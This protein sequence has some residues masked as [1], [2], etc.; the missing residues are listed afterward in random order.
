VFGVGLRNLEQRTRML[1]GAAATLAL[2][3]REGGGV[4]ARLEMPCAC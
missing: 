2:S 4:S 3:Q 1:H